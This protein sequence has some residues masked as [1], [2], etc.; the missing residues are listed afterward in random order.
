MRDAFIRS[1]FELAEK[2]SD[3]MLLTGDLGYGAFEK[4]EE[5]YP[6]QYLNVGVAEQNMIGIATGLA[7]DGKKIFIYSIGNFPTL[8]CLEQ[9]RNDAC[10]HQL[11]INIVGFGGG[12]SYGGL[13]MSHHATEDLAI[14]RALPGT[15]VLAPS[16]SEE[17]EAAVMNLYNS[18]GVGYLRLEKVA[19]KNIQSFK[20][21]SI[22]KSNI[23]RFGDDITII[24]VGSIASEAMTAA[25]IL[26]QSDI[27]CRVISLFSV[28]PIDTE[29]I[30]KACNDTAGI[31]T[32]EEGNLAGGMGSAILEVCSDNGFKPKSF[33]RFGLNN[34]YSAIVGSQEYLRSTYKINSIEVTDYILE[35][36]VKWKK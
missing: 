4:F 18:S 28:K 6:E 5:M 16:T 34:K 22:G 23:M 10:Y 17:T 32:I 3:V 7:M 24:V 8:R 33:K 26:S 15:T 9:I 30:K 12:F 35:E 11:N 1:L 21:I 31:V 29:V 27:E 36:S 25:N 2:D 20:N 14:M 19:C 13:G